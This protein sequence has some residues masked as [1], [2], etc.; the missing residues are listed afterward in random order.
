MVAIQPVK[1]RSEVAQFDITLADINQPGRTWVMRESKGEL[2]KFLRQRFV[3]K[4]PLALLH[5]PTHPD[6]LLFPESL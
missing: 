4:Q 6:E 1:Q 3:A 5:Q 2:L